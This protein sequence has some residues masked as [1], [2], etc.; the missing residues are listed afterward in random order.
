MM[1]E[2]LKANIQLPPNQI[3]M[4]GIAKK[5]L[6]TSHKLVSHLK[7]EEIYEVS[8]RKEFD[9]YTI[10][11]IDGAVQMLITAVE[12]EK[13]NTVNVPIS[14]DV[15]V[16]VTRLNIENETEEDKKARD[17]IEQEIIPALAN[18]YV[19]VVVLYMPSMEAAKGMV[20]RT[21]VI[22]FANA[23]MESARNRYEGTKVV[24]KDFALVE[25]DLNT[26]DVVEAQKRVSEA[27]VT[28]LTI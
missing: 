18:T 23:V 25:F 3:T 6:L 12:Q 5:I 7:S 10:P 24:E 11:M 4:E 9:A 28:Q 17:V 21:D 22:P 13:K 20:K 27:R 15:T 1:Q 26:T 14:K 8:R 16:E 2:I 19:Y